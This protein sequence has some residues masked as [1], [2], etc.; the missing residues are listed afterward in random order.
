[1]FYIFL[2]E[3]YKSNNKS[4]LLEDYSISSKSIGVPNIF[5]FAFVEEK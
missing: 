2:I 1:M 4:M 3:Q 5:K